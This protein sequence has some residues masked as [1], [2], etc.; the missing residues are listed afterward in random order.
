MP[1]LSFWIE[2]YSKLLVSR[3][4]I[5]AR[6]SWILGRIRP[7]VLELPA[8][9]WRNVHI[10]ELKYV[11]SQLANLDQILYVTLSGRGEDCI[12]GL[13]ADWIKTLVSMAT[14]STHWHNGENDVTTFSR[15][16]L[17]RS[18]LYLQVSRTCTKSRTGLNFG[19]IGPLTTESAALEVKKKKKIP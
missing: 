5:K 7:L 2:S 8:L 11:W 16:F 4:G 15:L 14:E 19:Q 13:W 10:F 17:I 3:T 6:S 12:R 9:E 18:F 1:A